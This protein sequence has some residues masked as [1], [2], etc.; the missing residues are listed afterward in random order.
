MGSDENHFN[1]SLI[2]MD[3]TTTF[4][5]KGESKWIRTEVPLLTSLKPYRWAKLAHSIRHGGCGEVEIIMRRAVPCVGI[6]TETT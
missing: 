4:E 5:E 3:K 6:A 2:V 1:V